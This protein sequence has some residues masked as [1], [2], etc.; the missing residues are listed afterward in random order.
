MHVLQRSFATYLGAVGSAHDA[1]PECQWQE[2]YMSQRETVQIYKL[3][4]ERIQLALTST[5]EPRYSNGTTCGTN[6]YDKN[7]GANKNANKT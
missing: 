1:V 4:K 5:S 2:C 6:Y 3:D 7:A